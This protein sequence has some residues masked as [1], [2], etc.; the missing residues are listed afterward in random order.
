MDSYWQDQFRC[1]TEK[2]ALA[3]V[4]FIGKKDNEAA[5]EAAV[6]AMRKSL[7]EIN[8]KGRIVIGEGER[9]KAPMLYIGE[10]LGCGFRRNGY[11]C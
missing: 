5:D 11:C 9:D 2:A 7:N 3:C 1:V 6:S 4:S 10:V 8:F